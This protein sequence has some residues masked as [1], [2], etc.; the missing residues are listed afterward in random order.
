MAD[1]KQT[2]YRVTRTP[3][4]FQLLESSA[5]I[6]IEQGG[7]SS[8][9]TYTTLQVL[10]D[11]AI[12][13]KNKVITIVGQDVPNLKKGAYRDA[14]TIWAREPQYQ[15]L[16]GKPNE[17]DR[18]FTCKSTGSIIEFAS[19]QDEQDAK[20]GKRDYLFINEANGIPYNI[21]WQLYIRTRRK[22]FIDYNPTTRFWAHDLIGQPD[23]E[24]FYTDHRNNDYLTKDE[25]DRIEN[26]KDKELWRVYARGMTGAISGLIFRNWILCDDM[27]EDYKWRVIGLDFGYNDPTAIIDIRF[28]DGIIWLDELCYKS[29][30][31]TRDIAE[32]LD[33]YDL[34]RGKIPII[35]DS[36]GKMSI[37]ELKRIYRFK[38]EPCKKGADSIVHGVQ[39]MQ[40]YPIRITRRS[41]NLRK[42]FETYKWKVDKN[43]NTMNEPIDEFNHAIDASRYGITSKMGKRSSGFKALG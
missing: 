33:S 5:K 2:R 21:F 4:Y 30:M 9:K 1:E 37:E 29:D 38:I 14:K 35:A 41:R 11:I 20:S 28:A 42:E 27:P 6:V 34:R 26:I 32:E 23:V 17:S 13:E 22:T 19:Y 31:V 8:G 25:H 18:V 39:T 3:Y 12:S 24:I 15:E 10:F 40:T 16:F 43:G 36:A 7:T